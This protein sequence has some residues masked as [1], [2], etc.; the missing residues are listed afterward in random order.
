MDFAKYAIR[1]Q[2]PDSAVRPAASVRETEERDFARSAIVHPRSPT[3]I[4][5][6]VL[7]RCAERWWFRNHS[8]RTG[9]SRQESITLPWAVF[10]DQSDVRRSYDDL[11][12]MLNQRFP[13][14]QCGSDLLR[15]FRFH[16][17][18]WLHCIGSS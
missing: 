5:K 14:S 8:Q 10:Q 9:I 16:V 1:Y 6:Y 12:F 2:I 17:T 11:R 4:I 3:A 15:A 13:S 7:R 18:Q